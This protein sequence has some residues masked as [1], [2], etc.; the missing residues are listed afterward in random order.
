[1]NDS[2]N[3]QLYKPN[4]NDRLRFYT[5]ELLRQPLSLP[6]ALAL[7]H[8]PLIHAELRSLSRNSHLHGRPQYL[9]AVQTLDYPH[10]A[11]IRPKW[12]E[13]QFHPVRYNFIPRNFITCP[14]VYN[15][16][17]TPR[18]HITTGVMR[19]PRSTRW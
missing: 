5:S 4:E 11:I 2:F 8:V 15:R 1:M 18:Q 19:R 10:H 9:H 16:L 6:F 7:L 13:V 12:T 17:L 3:Q 14:L